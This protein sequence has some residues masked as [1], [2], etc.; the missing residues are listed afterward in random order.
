MPGFQLW[1]LNN[2]FADSIKILSAFRINMELYLEN[3]LISAEEW[4]EVVTR[5][6]AEAA[7][8]RTQWM[9]VFER[10]VLDRARD[11]R[12]GVL[13]SG[14]VDSTLIA[15]VL[16]RNGIP[17]ICYTVGFQDEGTKQPE[18]VIEA[19]RIAERYGW[20]CRVQVLN[21]EE[22]ERIIVRTIGILGDAANPITVGVGA[23]VVA[24]AD[25]ALEDGVTMLFSGLGSEEIFAGY[26]R[27]GK[28][29]D[30]QEECWDGLVCM[31]ERDLIR[32][33]R[34]AAA[35]GVGIATPFLDLQVLRTGMLL[36][37]KIKDGVK[38]YVLREMAVEY[39]LPHEFAFRPKRAAQYGSRID[40][41]LERLAR[42]Q[43]L[44]KKEYVVRSR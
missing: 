6:R 30:V 40:G 3:G 37:P 32:D 21:L 1:S 39:G 18:D 12:V 4:R 31:R 20:D 8:D 42:R 27:H 15:F 36:E 9:A 28:A 25:A 17:F 26:E 7:P 33:T 43:G 44:S 22:T 38:K 41:A 29:V 19:R 13:F 11:G 34:I 35:M 5:L 23:V 10:A 2:F 24:A 14:G 16:H